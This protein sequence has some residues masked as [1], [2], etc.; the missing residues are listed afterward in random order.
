[1]VPTPAMVKQ[2]K[3]ASGY[4]EPEDKS[5]KERTHISFLGLVFI[6]GKARRNPAWSPP[7]RIHGLRDG[8]EAAFL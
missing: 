4:D 7:D 3:T 6:E 8:A 2:D 1:M 5:G